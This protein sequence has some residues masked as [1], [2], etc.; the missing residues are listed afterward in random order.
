MQKL[1]SGV[2]L[3]AKKMRK[4]GRIAAILLGGTLF[5]KG[6]AIKNGAEARM[7]PAAICNQKPCR[8]EQNE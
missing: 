3:A 4:L 2:R 8:K 1:R 7:G 5:A 6:E